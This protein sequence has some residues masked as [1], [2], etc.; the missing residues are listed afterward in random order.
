MILLWGKVLVWSS[1]IKSK[2]DYL[3]RNQEFSPPA[4]RAVTFFLQLEKVTRPM[5]RAA[6]TEG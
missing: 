4:G 2:Y 5:Y 3:A 1:S 6:A